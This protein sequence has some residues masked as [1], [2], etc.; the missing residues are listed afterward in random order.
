MVCF[1]CCRAN[2]C[3]TLLHP[4]PLLL[5]LLFTRDFYLAAHTTYT[6]L[7]CVHRAAVLPATHRTPV[8]E[9]PLYLPPLLPPACDFV[10]L[11]YY[12]SQRQAGTYCHVLRG[13]LMPPAVGYLHG[14]YPLRDLTPVLPYTTCTYVGTYPYLVRLLYNVD[15]LVRSYYTHAIACCRCVLYLP[16]RC[17]PLLENFP[18]LRFCAFPPTCCYGRWL[19]CRVLMPVISASHPCLQL[20][21][22]AL[23]VGIL[24]RS[25]HSYY[26]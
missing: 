18:R 9:P 23:L 20:L 15:Y 3:A 26:L 5:H 10:I 14:Y 19:L 24:Y 8:E 17:V 13:V 2:N 6:H 22:V 12:S 11:F 25:S 4:V 7:R 21:R 16:M 1:A